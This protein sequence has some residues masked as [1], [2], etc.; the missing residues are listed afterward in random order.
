VE[1]MEEFENVLSEIK[2]LSNQ[3]KNV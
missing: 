3:L 1:K 2:E